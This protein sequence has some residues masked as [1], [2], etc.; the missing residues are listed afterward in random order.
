[1]R[2]EKSVSATI[3]TLDGQRQA[4]FGFE[5]SRL[6]DDKEVLAPRHFSG[7]GAAIFSGIKHLSRIG[8]GQH[9]FWP[10]AKAG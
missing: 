4:A 2:V 5:K 7:G 9:N 10:G 3:R 8:R 6:M 1:L